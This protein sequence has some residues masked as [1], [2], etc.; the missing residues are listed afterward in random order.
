[1]LTVTN[2]WHLEWVETSVPLG[3]CPSRVSELCL[4]LKVEIKRQ[5]G[6]C[7]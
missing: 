1:M 6:Y 5:K 4:N 2:S 7:W 3:Q